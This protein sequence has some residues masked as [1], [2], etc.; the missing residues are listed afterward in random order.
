MV[1]DARDFF[2]TD[3]DG[4]GKILN[5]IT[6]EFPSDTIRLNEKVTHIDSSVEGKVVVTVVD[7]EQSKTYT[8]SKIIVSFSVGVLKH[9]EQDLFTPR[10]PREKIV[11]INKLDS[12]VYTKIF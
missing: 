9:F 5:Q 1:S 8:A 10:L 7:G 6:R 3:S 11:A 4:F 12:N 2:V